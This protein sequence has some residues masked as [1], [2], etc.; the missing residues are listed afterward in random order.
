VDDLLHRFQ[1]KRLGDTVYRVGR[2]LRRKLAPGDRMVGALRACEE[3]GG[4]MFEIILGIAMALR[5]SYSD[6]D[7]R[8]EQI[9][10][11]ICG[12]SPYEPAYSKILNVS[13]V[14]YFDK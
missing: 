13:G 2:D 7:M 4:D 14:D 1:N 8:R 5:F 10:T 3:Y 12:I 11:D 9:L 6:L